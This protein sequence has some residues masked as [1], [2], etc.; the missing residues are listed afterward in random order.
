[1]EIECVNCK[2]SGWVCENHPFQPWN[3]G[4]GCCGGAGDPCKICNPSDREN[5][6]RMLAGFK[7]ID[8]PELLEPTCYAT[9][10]EL[11]EILGKSKPEAQSLER[12]INAILRRSEIKQVK[13]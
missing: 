11:F 13:S 6:P 3:D 7:I 2:S 8:E 4:D 12:G 9:S 1:M 5:P 10:A